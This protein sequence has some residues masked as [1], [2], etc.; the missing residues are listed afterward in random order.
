MDALLLRIDGGAQLDSKGGTVHRVSGPV[1]VAV[2]EVVGD[3]GFH[4]E[5]VGR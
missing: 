1:V 3:D 5:I 2:A 4:V